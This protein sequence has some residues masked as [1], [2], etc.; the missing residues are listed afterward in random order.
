MSALK[1]PRS[2]A[3]RA[4]DRR[5]AGRPAVMQADADFNGTSD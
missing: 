1:S 5:P 2:K 4:V 3:S